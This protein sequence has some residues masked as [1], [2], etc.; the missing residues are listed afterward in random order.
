ARGALV[1]PHGRD[2]ACA[3]H[4]RLALGT[5]RLR[6]GS[7]PRR[8]GT[9]ARRRRRARAAP[10]RHVRGTAPHRAR[11]D[12]R[13]RRGDHVSDRP[14]DWR[15]WATAETEHITSAGQWR[16]PRS[17][18]P[19]EPDALVSFASN[20]YLGLTRHPAVR[21]AA[22]AAIDRWGTGAGAA[23]LIVGSRPVHHDLE[24][25]LAAWKGT[26]AA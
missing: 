23:R 2:R 15:E 3:A 25:E 13:A 17:Y 19:A 18:D 1:R 16:R 10:H 12:G 22:H 6:G 26:E 21:A 8:A 7:C 11:A 4:R 20:D 5:A 24:S 9:T 14:G